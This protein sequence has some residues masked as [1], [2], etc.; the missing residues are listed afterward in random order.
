MGIQTQMHVLNTATHSHSPIHKWKQIFKKWFP[1]HW[2]RKYAC[3]MYILFAY[4][5]IKVYFIFYSFFFFFFWDLYI[6]DWASE[7]FSSKNT[8]KHFQKCL[9]FIT[10]LILNTFLVV[11][12]SEICGCCHIF[13]T[14]GIR[15]QGCDPEFKSRVLVILSDDYLA[16][17]FPHSLDLHFTLLIASL[18]V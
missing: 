3:E 5:F 6:L 10:C 13:T 17:T 1:L 14:F 18:A 15:S 8:D 9:R 2:A 7:T 11:T 12:C 16:H 4:S